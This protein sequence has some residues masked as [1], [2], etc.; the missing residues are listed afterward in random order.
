M[1]RSGRHE[2]HIMIKLLTATLFCCDLASSTWRVHSSA[3]ERCSA[4]RLRCALD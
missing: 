4:L 1:Q 2:A 3:M